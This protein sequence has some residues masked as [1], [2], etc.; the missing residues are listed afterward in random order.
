MHLIDATSLRLSA[1]SQDWAHFSQSA[2]GA[3]LHVIYDPDADR[4]VY[5]VVTAAKIN[6]ITPAKATPIEPGATYVFDLGHYDY[7]W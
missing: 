3:K 6:D 2:C 7:G 4:P 5:A 1:L